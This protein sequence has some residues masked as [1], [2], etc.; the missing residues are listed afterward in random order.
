MGLS[1]SLKFLCWTPKTHVFWNTVRNARSRLSK[2]I[3]FGTN[4]KRVCDFIL[5]INSNI[6]P[7]LPLFRDTGDFLLITA[8]P[9]LFHLNFGGIPHGLDCRCCGS[10]ARRPY[11]NSWNYFRTNP[12][13]TPT[14]PQRPR[15]TTHDSNTAVKMKKFENYTCYMIDECLRNVVSQN[16]SKIVIIWVSYRQRQSGPFSD[17]EWRRQKQKRNVN[18]YTTYAWTDIYMRTDIIQCTTFAD[19]T[20]NGSIPLSV[21]EAKQHLWYHSV[22]YNAHTQSTLQNYN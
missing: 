22:I 13:H 17:K 18:N 7:I 5:V 9:P 15:R 3:D 12:T 8:T 6:G 19:I 10:E 20:K 14:V 4:W 2:V 1:Y 11:A 16:V 21:L